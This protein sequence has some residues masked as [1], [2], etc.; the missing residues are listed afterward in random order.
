M[1]EITHSA[2]E[3]RMKK[4]KLY[5]EAKESFTNCPD[6]EELTLPIYVASFVMLFLDMKI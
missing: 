3:F 4:Y 5:F 2:A 6:R 1:F